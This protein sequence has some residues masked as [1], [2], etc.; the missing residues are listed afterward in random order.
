MWWTVCSF[1]QELVNICSSME[2]REKLLKPG[3]IQPQ[4]QGSGVR[5]T[6]TVCHSTVCMLMLHVS[7]YLLFQLVVQFTQWTTGQNIGHLLSSNLS[8]WLLLTQTL[9]AYRVILKRFSHSRILRA[10]YISS[11]VPG[12]SP[13][14]Q[15]ARNLMTS[16]TCNPET[17]YTRKYNTVIYSLSKMMRVMVM[18]MIACC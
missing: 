10:T 5:V 4:G 2:V 6:H 13:S 11:A 14:T 7:K 1:T 15:H 3:T 17:Q 12:S 16:E 8:Q 9:I 18:V